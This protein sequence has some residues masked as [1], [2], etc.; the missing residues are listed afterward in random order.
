LPS[1]TGKSFER[2]ALG[3]NL[4]VGRQLALLR[5]PQRLLHQA[6][7]GAVVVQRVDRLHH[8]RDGGELAD[9][10]GGGQQPVAQA[11]PLLPEL[12]RLGAQHQVREVDVPGVRRHVRALGHVAHVAQVALV[13]HLPVVLFGDAVDLHRLAFIDQ[14][15]QGRERGA[16]THAAAAAVADLVDPFEFLVERRRVPEGVAL[17]VERVAGGRFQVAFAFGHGFVPCGRSQVSERRSMN[18]IDFGN[19]ADWAPLSVARGVD[20]RQYRS[21]PKG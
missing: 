7:R 20:L 12:D 13:D 8:H 3:R 19:S 17:P 2:A 5:H 10:V 1:F 18:Q 16:Q 4:R 15:E 11:R 6:A 14:V 9:R 21:A